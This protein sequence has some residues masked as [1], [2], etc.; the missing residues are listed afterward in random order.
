MHLN[1]ERVFSVLLKRKLFN[2]MINAEK[3]EMA[4]VRL[5]LKVETFLFYIN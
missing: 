4:A 5:Q 2:C 3:S 1:D